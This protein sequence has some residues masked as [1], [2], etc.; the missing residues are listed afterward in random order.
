M[1]GLSLV[2]RGI[3]GRQLIQAWAFSF[4]CVVLHPR[5]PPSFLTG[6]ALQH[7]GSTQP[8]HEFGRPGPRLRCHGRA[9]VGFPGTAAPELRRPGAEAKAS[10]PLL[11]TRRRCRR[12]S[13]NR[14][15]ESTV[16]VPHVLSSARSEET[17]QFV[18]MTGSWSEHLAIAS[19]S[20]RSGRQSR[21]TL[22]LQSELACLALWVIN[23]SLM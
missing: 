6:H 18:H 17:P 13:G 11:A 5:L 20:G 8:Q 1:W 10:A 4:V 21:S 23:S 7:F 15:P 19:F 2:G 3:R 14:G 22:G 9:G 12:A 16:A